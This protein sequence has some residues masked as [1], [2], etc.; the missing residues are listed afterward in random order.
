MMIENEDINK[1]NQWQEFL[2]TGKHV[3]LAINKPED[4]RKDHVAKLKAKYPDMRIPNPNR[5][6]RVVSPKQQRAVRRQE[7]GRDNGRF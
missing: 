7:G 5:I 6:I 4:K 2:E 3:P 1:D